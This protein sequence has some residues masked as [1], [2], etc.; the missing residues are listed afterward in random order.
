MNTI[1]LKGTWKLEQAERGIAIPAGIPGDNCSALLA[2]GIIPDPYYRENES[3][4]KWLG[5]AD[6]TCS[7]EFEVKEKFLSYESIYLNIEIL[8]T[9]AVIRI[10]GKKVAVTRNMFKR[11]RIEVKEYLK[12]GKNHITILF[13]SAAKEAQKKSEKLPFPI[14]YSGC[15]T[16]PHLN[17]VRKVQCHG[18]WDWGILLMVSGIY[19]DISL[20]GANEA[21]IEHIY[22]E[23]AHE[24][25]KCTVTVC[26]ELNTVRP[27]KIEIEFS[28]G[29]ETRKIRQSANTGINLVKTEFEINNPKLWWP[30]GYGSQ[31]LYDLT[32]KTADESLSRK[33]GLRTIELVCAKDDYGTGMKFRVNG[34]DVFCKG[35]NWIPVDAMPG[36]QTR[37][38]YKDLLESAVSANMNMIRVWGGGQYEAECFYELCDELGLLVWQD[39]M[40]ACSQYPS[41]DD[42][43]SNVNEELEY[44]IKRL[45]SHASVA[46]WCGDNECLGILKWL[47][48]YQK[49]PQRYMDNYK[50]LD[51][52]RKSA[53]NKYG[54]EYTYWPS[55]PCE[56]PG[57]FNGNWS[58]DHN[59]DMHYWKVWHGGE[60][61]EAYFNVIPRFCSEFGFQSFPSREVFDTFGTQEDA[62]VFSPVMLHHQKNQNGNKFITRMFSKYFHAPEGFDNFLYLSQVQQALA[63]KTGVEFWRHL[64]PV[65]MG[66]LYWQLNDNWPVAS[67]SSLE[68]GG[69]WKQLHYHA[70]RFYAPQASMAFQKNDEL[71]IWS[72]NDSRESQIFEVKAAV[73]DFSGRELETRNFEIE[74]NA[75]SSKKLETLKLAEAGFE[76]NETFM[77]LETYAAGKTHVN[78]HF[79]VPYKDCKLPE[80]RVK[81]KVYEED[82][83]LKVELFCDKPAFFVTLETPEVKGI[84]EDNSITLLPDRKKVIKF[85]PKQST[86]IHELKKSLTI[87]H[88][89]ETYTNLQTKS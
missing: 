52:V 27:R 46:L 62:D 41:T 84:F 26:A 19:G 82:K 35:A 57:T 74:I 40:F 6:W 54:P 49:Y 69:K 12:A 28:F 50:R 22:T 87:K 56:G 64:Q 68:Y 31:P 75:R 88:L 43:I 15:N 18:G 78:T 2:A 53:V 67:W 86:N 48:E 76:K 80:T 8:D 34:V 44:Q 9:I 1:D 3:G 21:R 24:K 16:I 36:R 77:L 37:E 47:D 66:T 4:T 60:P 72:V 20:N 89:R 17:L 85:Y 25:S 39:M 61:L 11:H 23:Q 14:P 71:E 10:N 65:C 79:F 7:R 58:N 5:D 33:T 81:T 13:K 55:S 42:F 51:S 83:L 45:K 59:G 73:Y 29:G 30:S 38:V 63:I 70:K 32:V